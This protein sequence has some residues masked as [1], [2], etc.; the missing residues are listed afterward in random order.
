MVIFFQKIQIQVTYYLLMDY[1]VLDY[2]QVPFENST[3]LGSDPLP[4]VALV[5]KNW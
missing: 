5:A 4:K 1:G 3:I 2:M